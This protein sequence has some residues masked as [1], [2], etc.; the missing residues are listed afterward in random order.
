MGIDLFSRLRILPGQY[1]PGDM[2]SV[3]EYD[4]DLI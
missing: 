3:I 4:Y 1:S 2:T